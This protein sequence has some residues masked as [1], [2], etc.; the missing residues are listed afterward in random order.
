MPYDARGNPLAATFKDYLMPTISDVPDFEYLHANTPS[1]TIGGMRGVGE[2]GAI[3]GP[4][5]LVNAIADALAPF[6]ELGGEAGE[7]TL[8][9]TPSRI[10]DLIEQRNV[11]GH[12]A[13]AEKAVAATVAEEVSAETVAVSPETE[14]APAT[15]SIDGD[16]DMTLKAPMGGQTFLAHFD[17]EGTSLSGYLSAPEGRQEF[18]GGTFEDGRMKFEVKV[19]KP[20]K[21]TLKYD[22]QATA[23]SI[24]GKCK[25]GMFGTAKVNAVRA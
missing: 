5:T 16:W 22:L 6:G 19:D 18:S 9:L 2:G 10:L 12:Q 21:V 13:P 11:S 23:D 20:M 3:I 7:V 1:Q 15:A 24:T 25:M 14:P 8:P 17:T 4:P